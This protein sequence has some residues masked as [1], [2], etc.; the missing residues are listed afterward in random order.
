MTFSS[1]DT[2]TIIL[3]VL[4]AVP[5]TI[6]AI[7]NLIISLRTN[8]AVNGVVADRVHAAKAEGALAEIKRTQ[9]S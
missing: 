9:E 6:T 7:A 3:A 4:V 5:V 8:K 2:K 1:E